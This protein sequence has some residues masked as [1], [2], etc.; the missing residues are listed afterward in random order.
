MK[1][2]ASEGRRVAKQ[3]IGEILGNLNLLKTNKVKKKV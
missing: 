2:A 1:G 3:I